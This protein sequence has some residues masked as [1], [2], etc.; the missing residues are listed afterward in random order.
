VILSTYLY[1]NT[2]LL[3]LS[4]SKAFPH[5]LANNSGQVGRNYM[6]HVYSGVNG[7]FPGQKLNR[8][9]GPGAQRTTVDDWNADNFDHKGLG[10]I[11]GGVIDSRAENKPL[12]AARTTPP[13]VPLFGTAWKDWL[14]KNANSV[15]DAFAQIESLPYEDNFLDLDPTVKDPLGV[16]VI[17]ATFDLHEQE[18]A[19]IAFL[20]GKL[21]NLL[22]EAGA[23]E[24]WVSFP[25]IPIAVN[26]HAYG[27]TRMGDD[28]ATSVVNRWSMA[29][30]VPNL[31]IIGGSTFPTS[32]AY[33]PTNTIE[34]LAW[35]TGEHIAKHWKA[36]A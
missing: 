25:P 15:G 23:S 24:T 32:T 20:N 16:P 21:T 28:R 18:K 35:R 9:G 17:R 5:G 7:L 29:H 2:R 14:A 13:S 31:A 12:A 19:R 6:S 8:W 10:F 4:R 22:K 34:A 33:N 11:G 3:L 1:E 36:I 26:S 27:T 30:E